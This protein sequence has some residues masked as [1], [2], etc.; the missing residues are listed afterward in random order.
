MHLNVSVYLDTNPRVWAVSMWTNVLLILIH[1]LNG[2]NV[3]IHLVVTNVHVS[4]ASKGRLSKQGI[5]VLCTYRDVDNHITGVPTILC[6]NINECHMREDDC[7]EF[8]HCEDNYG[9]WECI[10]L[11][12]YRGDGQ[13]KFKLITLPYSANYRN[14][15]FESFVSILTNVLKN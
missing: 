13:E 7:H 15:T 3:L 6:Q 9:S 1:V 14:Y 10:C 11:N 2:L 12:G 4:Q 5:R 8:A